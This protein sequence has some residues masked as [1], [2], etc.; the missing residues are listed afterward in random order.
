MTPAQRARQG[1]RAGNGKYAEF[2][3][4]EQANDADLLDPWNPPQTATPD[5][6]GPGTRRPGPFLDELAVPPMDTGPRNGTFV[7]EDTCTEHLE[8]P[9]GSP[10]ARMSI[11]PGGRPEQRARTRA[12]AECYREVSGWTG[13]SLG[14]ELD[15]LAQKQAQATVLTI[16][17]NGMVRAVEG[18]I[19]RSGDGTLAYLPKGRRHSGYMLDPDKVLD[20]TPGYGGAPTLH[21]TWHRRRCATTPATVPVGD[22][23]D[24]PDAEQN[25][26]GNIA[27]VYLLDQPNFSGGTT[28][29][30]MFLATDIQPDGP[31][32]GDA[33]VN[34]Q[35]WAPGDSGLYSESS[36]VY[37]RDLRRRGGK[38]AD[39]APGSMSDS[40]SWKDMP[41]TRTEAYRKV[42]G[43]T[44]S[45]EG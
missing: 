9:A 42:M 18:R 4:G 21:N 45:T 29:G 30:C 41:S 39:F 37:V 35:F 38:V 44:Y 26:D 12:A 1:A 40:D 7:V 24:L 16:A 19:F 3:S 11:Q 17:S 22:C 20:V 36:S 6:P 10:F 8:S 5:G 43:F 15:R 33:I 2:T 14:D 23:T 13:E 32:P 27:A 31:D 25:P 28:P 34:G